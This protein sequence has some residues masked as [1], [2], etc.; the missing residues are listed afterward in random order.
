MPDSVGETPLHVA[1]RFGRV[2]PV[3]LLLAWGSA[4]D[5]QDAEGLTPLSKAAF[6][7]HSEAR[8]C[9]LRGLIFIPTARLEAMAMSGRSSASH[10]RW[11]FACWRTAP[12]RPGSTSARGAPC[13][14]SRQARRYGSSCAHRCLTGPVSGRPSTSPRNSWR[15]GARLQ[16]PTDEG[17]PMT[18]PTRDCCTP[19]PKHAAASGASQRGAAAL[20]ML[21]YMHHALSWLRERWPGLGDIAPCAQSIWFWVVH[22]TGA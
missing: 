13:W 20:Q 21:G 6:L 5:S 11:C 14:T 17:R 16:A 1:S 10:G 7:G 9:L 18:C 12:T 22:T 19:C 2:R 4:V 15:C 3:E 8:T